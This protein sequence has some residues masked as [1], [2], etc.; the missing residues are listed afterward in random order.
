MI[1]DFRFSMDVLGVR[2]LYLK[3][4][5]NGDASYRWTPDRTVSSFT[6]SMSCLGV[7]IPHTNIDSN[8]MLLPL[9]L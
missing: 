8:L 5:G 1:C 4:Y 9:Q 2:P 6:V 3:V 7:L